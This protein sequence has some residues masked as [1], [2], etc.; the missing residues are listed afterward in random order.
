MPTFTRYAVYYAPPP[1][2]L[3]DFGAA[4][5]GWDAARGRETAPPTIPALPAS[6]H[7][8]SAPARKYGFHATLKPPFRLAVASSEDALSADLSQLAAR[9]APVQ[10]S[11]LVLAPLGRFLAL[12]PESDTGP[13]DA[14]AGDVVRALDPHRAPPTE[15]ELARR[16]TARLSPSQRENLARWGYP[17]VMNDFRFHITLTGPLPRAMR[18]AAQAALMPHLQPL[19]PRPVPI[20][21]LC[22]FG[23][24]DDGQFHLISRHAL[25]GGGL[26]ALPG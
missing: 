25:G 21:D 18:D 16:R 17:H 15:A 6:P 2:A 14:L 4:W 26:S 22:L 3:A 19:L 11:G 24:A 7:E 8:L 20:D 23:E 13:L 10:L 5:L 9:L 12:L 1:G